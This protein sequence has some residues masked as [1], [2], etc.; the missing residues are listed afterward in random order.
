L[1]I[2]VKN[3]ILMQAKMVVMMQRLSLMK[4]TVSL[5]IYADL[6][7]GLKVSGPFQSFWGTNHK[8]LFIID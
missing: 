8:K 1:T 4:K 6:S 2:P 7:S 3:I 5:H